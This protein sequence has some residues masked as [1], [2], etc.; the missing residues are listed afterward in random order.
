MRKMPWEF[1][2]AKCREVGVEIFF[3]KDADDPERVGFPSD[4][5]RQ[6]KKICNTCV[7]QNDCALWGI[8]NE[9]HGM[10]GGLTP[11]ERR[12]MRGKSK[13]NIPK[14]IPYSPNR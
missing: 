5:Y 3:N 1:D 7:H 11:R 12:T 14:T 6:A 8:E 2:E 9:R 4:H 13:I 10:W